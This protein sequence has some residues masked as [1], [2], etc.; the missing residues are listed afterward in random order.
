MRVLSLF[1]GMSCGQIALERAGIPVDEYYAC[2]IKPNAIKVTQENYPNTTQM[3]DVTKVSGS[4]LNIDLLIGG[5]P[6]QD[7]TSINLKGGGLKGKKSSLFFEYVRLL[8]ECKPKYFLLENVAS[9]TNA[10]RDTISKHMGVEPIFINSK[11]LSAQE[12]RRYYWTNIPVEQ[13]EDLGIKLSDVISY[14]SDREESMSVKKYAHV[15][16]KRLGTRYVRLDGDKSMP[17]TA[18]SYASWNT[19][20]VT[21]ECGVRDLLL[22]EYKRL[23]TIPESYKF[24]CIKSKAVD[25]IGD[26][27]TVDVIAH[28]FKG[29]R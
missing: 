8:D 6:C 29:L 26:G 4:F 9:M 10:D 7:L 3:G 13:P 15:E 14:G 19:Q 12:R 17:I 16:K 23:Q 28:I 21:D 18:R 11:L 20:F 27:W 24:N 25:L 2:E 22:A 1:D 5:S